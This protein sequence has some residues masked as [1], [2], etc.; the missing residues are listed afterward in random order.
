MPT[1][2][3]VTF[4]ELQPDAAPP[5][6]RAIYDEIC[7]WSAVPMAALIF[8]N[9]A[10]H[11]GVLEEVWEGIAPL[12]RSGRLQ[13][14]AWAIAQSATAQGLLPPIEP[15]AR[16]LMGLTPDALAQIHI[17]LDAYNRANPV[18]L[19]TMLGLLERLQMTAA[20]RPM[21]PVA[22]TPPPAIPPGMP[23]M[24]RLDVMAPHMRRLINDLGVGDRTALDPVVPS[25]YRHLTDWPAYLAC[26]HVMLV[27]HFRDGTI[28]RETEAVRLAMASEA[29]Q[30]APFLPPMP[31]LAALTDVT[32]T[33]LYFTTVVIPQMI[34]IGG[35]MRR[36][37]A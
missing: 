22:W 32:A 26:L 8:R 11:P 12:M 9:L 33:L 31:R 18:N 27:P 1:P 2:A 28:A 23:K 24:A 17:T 10:T 19:L 35:A 37:L 30:I 7:H 21:A 25:L 34:V 29:A 5:H 16:A 4:P 13:E 20:A 6:I 15:N 14:P 36:S 3:G